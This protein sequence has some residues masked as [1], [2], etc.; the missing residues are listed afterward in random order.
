[1]NDYFKKVLI[2]A[3]HPDDETL[4]CGGLIAKAIAL[5]NEVRIVFIA[6]GSSSRFNN[7]STLEIKEA[8]S[9]RKECAIK[10]LKYLGIKE[11]E[12][13]F[14]DRKCCQLDNYPLLEITKEIENHINTFKPT[15]ILTHSL[16]D[17]NIDHRICYQALLPAVRPIKNCSLKLGL[18]FEILSS[19]EW[20]YLNQF[21]PNY[22]IDITNELEAKINSCNLYTGEMFAN[23]HPRSSESIKALAK[24]RG[25]QSGHSYSEGFKLLFSR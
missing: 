25:N 4:G 18:I 11:R 24:I 20:N 5:K 3:A 8:I 12:I 14:N 16:H 13:F 9:I 6:E 10:A 21:E 17:A 22:F 19:S 2:I 15:C 1:M 7:N 23:N